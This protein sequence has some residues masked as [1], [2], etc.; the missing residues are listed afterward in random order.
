MR[1]VVIF[2]MAKNRK[3]SV[4][5]SASVRIAA[6]E[7]QSISKVEGLVMPLEMRN[8]FDSFNRDGLSH[9]ARRAILTM[10]YGKTAG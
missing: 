6:R 5:Q 2:A 10:R 4:A 7:S 3:K 8:L 1:N 9:E